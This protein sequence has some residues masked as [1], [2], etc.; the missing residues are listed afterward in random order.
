MECTMPSAKFVPIDNDKTREYVLECL[1]EADRG[2]SF[3][4]NIDPKICRNLKNRIFKIET[5]VNNACW[6]KGDTND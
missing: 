4:R 3:L 6:R 2:L 1:S 5:E